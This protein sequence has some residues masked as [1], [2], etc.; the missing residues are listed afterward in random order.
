M[1]LDVKLLNYHLDCVEGAWANVPDGFAGRSVQ[2]ALS[3]TFP[4]PFCSWLEPSDV[5]RLPASWSA[6]E[7]TVVDG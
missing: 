3:T 6:T 7:I 2:L 5:G 1:T 4:E